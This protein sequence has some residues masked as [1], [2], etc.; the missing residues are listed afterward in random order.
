M[1]CGSDQSFT[2]FVGID[3]AETKH[4]ICVLAAGSKRREMACIA[5]DP[6]IIESRACSLRERVNR[7]RIVIRNSSLAALS[8][9]TCGAGRRPSSAPVHSRLCL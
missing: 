5:H 4:D 7:R 3:W 9:A 1:E 8:T 2:A 6:E